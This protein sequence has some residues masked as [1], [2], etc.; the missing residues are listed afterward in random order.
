MEVTVKVATGA[1]LLSRL[2]IAGLV[3]KP[4]LARI[5]YAPTATLVCTEVIAMR[6]LGHSA[7]GNYKCLRVPELLSCGVPNIVWSQPPYFFS[8]LRQFHSLPH[9]GVGKTTLCEPHHNLRGLLKH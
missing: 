4:I 7:L 3:I 9:V 8:F 1:D 6:V 2:F 5:Q